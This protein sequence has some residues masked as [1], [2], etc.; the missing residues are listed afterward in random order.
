MNGNTNDLS[1]LF[2]EDEESIRKNYIEFMDESFQN[3][4]E[5]CDGEQA[6]SIYQL[7]KPDILIVDI[8]MPKLNGLELVKRIRKS[9]HRTKII[10]LTAYSDVEYLLQAAE[11]KLIKYLVKPISRNELK[12][13]LLMAVDELSKYELIPKKLIS[14]KNDFYWDL[15]LRE[16]LHNGKSIVLTKK[17]KEVMGFLFANVNRVCTYNEIIYCIWT[18][19]IEDRL[20]SLKTI[21]KNLRKKLPEDTIKNVYQEGYKVEV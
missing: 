19:T 21:I 18:D 6:Y 3:V 15:E 14:L 7:Q 2:A 16:L 5:A 13:A 9:D 4:Y 8:N 12:D 20:G 17:E 10:V 1:I 11:L